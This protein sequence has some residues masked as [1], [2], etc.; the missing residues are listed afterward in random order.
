[1]AVEGRRQCSGDVYVVDAMEFGMHGLGRRCDA[2]TQASMEREI[3]GV[4]VRHI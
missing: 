4:A 1:V 3:D 2:C